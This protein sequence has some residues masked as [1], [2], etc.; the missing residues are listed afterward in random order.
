MLCAVSIFI[1]VFNFS[2]LVAFGVNQLL[3]K[4]SFFFFVSPNF[5]HLGLDGF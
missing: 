5:M 3:G 4:K 1:L 2:V